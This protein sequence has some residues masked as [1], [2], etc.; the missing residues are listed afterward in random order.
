MHRQVQNRLTAYLR[1]IDV[2]N[3]V[4]HTFEK[5]LGTDC[6]EVVYTQ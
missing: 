6:V 2:L 3:K 1:S 4:G 5:A